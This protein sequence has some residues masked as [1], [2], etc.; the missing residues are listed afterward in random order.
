MMA[1]Q[2]GLRHLIICYNINSRTESLWLYTLVLWNL[3]HNSTIASI[4]TIHDRRFLDEVGSATFSA[5]LCVCHSVSWHWTPVVAFQIKFYQPSET[6]HVTDGFCKNTLNSS[7]GLKTPPL[8]R[9]PNKKKRNVRKAAR[10]PC[11]LLPVSVESQRTLVDRHWRCTN[12][13]LC[14]ADRSQR[15]EW[16]LSNFLFCLHGWVTNIKTARP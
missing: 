14:R 11:D 7:A 12:T 15:N 4:D 9:N 10:S 16:Y 5:W 1:N 3:K 2:I 6:R 8:K 13:P